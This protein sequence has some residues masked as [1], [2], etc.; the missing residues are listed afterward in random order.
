MFG[1]HFLL[2][3]LPL[4]PMNYQVLAICPYELPSATPDPL[5]L[6][7]PSKQPLPSVNSVVTHG[8]CYYR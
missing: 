5:K 1:W 2:G 6:P 4:A 7:N 3:K 8:Q